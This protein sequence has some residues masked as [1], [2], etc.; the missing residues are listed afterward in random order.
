MIQH[1]IQYIKNK[2]ANFIRHPNTEKWVEETRRS[3]V[4]FGQLGSAWM[5]YE[6]LFRVFDVT[7]QSISISH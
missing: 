7:S 5:S 1:V 6:T 3:Q 2:E 4:F